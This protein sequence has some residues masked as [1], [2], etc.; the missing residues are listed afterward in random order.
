MKI[1]FW[2]LVAVNV[3]LFAGMKF[4]DQAPAGEVLQAMHAEKIT[5]V[6]PGVVVPPLTA[7][8]AVVVS[9]VAPVAAA[10]SSVA[11]AP[12]LAAPVSAS[13]P[14]PASTLTPVKSSAC[15]E[16][17]EFSGAELDQVSSRL[18]KLQLGNRVSRREID[19]GIGFWVYVPPLKDKVAVNQKVEQL[20]ALGVTDYF[21]VQDAG[22]WLN[23]ISLGVFKS[24]DAAQKFLAGLRTKNVS[25]AQ[26]GERPSKNRSIVF[27]INDLDAKMS[28]GLI[29]LQKDFSESE[30]KR[31]TCH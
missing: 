21:V 2:L 10:T 7:A 4:F 26:M 30:L 22:E 15:Y 8:S 29:V 5:I 11:S 6:Q 17:G 27:I 19:H 28:A 20:K 12:V 1:F 31:V 16:W 14:V 23:A 3:I 9:A 18:K 13:S 25:S 24:R